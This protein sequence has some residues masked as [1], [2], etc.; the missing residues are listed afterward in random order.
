[1]KRNISRLTLAVLLTM[2]L[3]S[4][5]ASNV[6]SASG[7]DGVTII[8]IEQ[9]NEAGSTSIL[10]SYLGSSSS[11][12][13]GASGIIIEENEWGCYGQTDNPHQTIHYDIKVVNV[14][15]RTKCDDDRM[16]VLWVETQLYREYNCIF[17][18][19]FGIE[20]WGA[21]SEQY[22]Y[23]EYEA[24]TWSDGPCLDSTYYK[25]ISAHLMEDPDGREYGILTQKR[26]KV[27]TC[28]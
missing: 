12:A 15:A 11:G 10:R 6:L 28:P 22:E 7:H 20:P 16:P 17:S 1:M 19:C 23:N 24:T 8:T 5:S 9:M 21:E 26:A 14:H 2:M 27:T 3:V 25:G 4:I 13:S 18:V